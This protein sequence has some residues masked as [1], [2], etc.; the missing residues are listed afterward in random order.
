M[1]LGALPSRLGKA[2]LPMGI[3]AACLRQLRRIG[4]FQFIP[5]CAGRVKTSAL[6][7]SGALSIQWA[8][9][10]MWRL[11]FS[12][13]HHRGRVL[14]EVGEPALQPVQG[15]LQ[16]SLHL[17]QRAFARA[18]ERL[19]QLARG[20]AGIER[21]DLKERVAFANRS[22]LFAKRRV[23]V[24]L[25]IDLEQVQRAP[26]VPGKDLQHLAGAGA[27]RFC[28]RGRRVD[29]SLCGQ[30]R[31]GGILEGFARPDITDNTEVIREQRS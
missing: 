15:F 6:M 11:I 16:V 19:D 25:R 23:L 26:E 28:R 2:P 9:S 8:R 22:D 1:R 7:S 10:T 20:K 17:K 24:I 30:L 4:R 14:G 18:T 29:L 5:A 31:Q 3:W 27:K 12:P 13:T 21:E